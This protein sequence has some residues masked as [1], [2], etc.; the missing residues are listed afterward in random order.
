MKKIKRR[1]SFWKKAVGV[2]VS[3]TMMGLSLV[4]CSSGSSSQQDAAESNQSI[5]ESVQN[6]DT[7]VD[8]AVTLSWASNSALPNLDKF[9]QTGSIAP[10]VAKLWGDSL[11]ESDHEGGYVGLLAEE[12]EFSE[13]SLSCDITLREGVTF[14]NGE[15]LTA[16]DVKFTLERLAEL[17]TWNAS[18]WAN[19]LDHVEVVDDTHCT[20][21]FSA[22]MPTFYVEACS[23]AILNK[24]ACEADEEAFWKAPVGVGAFRV[25]SFDELSGD[26]EMERNDDW[27]G[28]EYYGQT[29]DVD[30]IKFSAI[31][32]D[33]TR[34]ASLRSGEV[35]VI[36]YVPNDS[37]ELL[38]SEGFTTVSTPSY[39]HVYLGVNVADGKTF[40]DFNLRQ[41]LSLCID[42]QLLCDSVL[43]AGTGANWPCNPGTLGYNGDNEYKYDLEEAKR[44]VEASNYDGSELSLIV[45]TSEITRGSEVAQ[46]IQSF[47]S[48][49]GFNVS[50]NPLESATY[51]DARMA[52]NYDMALAI[53]GTNLEDNNMEV[54]EVIGGDRFNTGFDN[55]E[56]KAICA[57][58]MQ[59]VDIETRSDYYEQAY[60]IVF[61]NLYPNISL[62]YTESCLA[63]AS[64][65]SNIAS[66]TGGG[67]DLRFV[68][69]E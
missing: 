21:V 22:V 36:E 46:A 45:N 24:A 31:I 60:Q 17:G 51:D 26:V 69:K 27:W 29:S 19:Y 4:A 56:L 34:V 28:W 50:V 30:T 32:E 35:D 49:A 67:Y 52:G 14:S 55:D 37:I 42:R 66:Y 16:E 13:D 64:N 11:I 61:D 53:M 23:C 68:T 48:E 44:L 63:Y 10:K 5:A 41:A 39:E 18:K 1:D 2:V 38:D 8:G 3:M 25:V 47:C 65:V 12:W 33:T 15:P 59:Y 57:E 6:E 9:N 20:I 54:A 40:N 58:A 43:G 62:Y 7:G